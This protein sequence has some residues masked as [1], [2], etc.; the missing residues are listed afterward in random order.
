MKTTFMICSIIFTLS[1]TGCAKDP[2][3]VTDSI[4]KAYSQLVTALDAKT[5]CDDAAKKVIELNDSSIE[6]IRTILN[7]FNGLSRDNKLKVIEELTKQAKDLN[8]QYWVP[9]NKRCTSHSPQIGRI[10]GGFMR[11]FGV[12]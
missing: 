5:S 6:N 2:K 11:R 4:M 8:K 3:V 7:D 1:L 10:I 9:F 12:E